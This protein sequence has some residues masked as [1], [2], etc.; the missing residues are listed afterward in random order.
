[1]KKAVLL[2]VVFILLFSFTSCVRVNRE[3]PQFMIEMISRARQII[4]AAFPQGEL[5]F[6]T[7]MGCFEEQDAQA[8]GAKTVDDIISWRF[9]FNYDDGQRKSAEISWLE[10]AWQAP[11]IVN[12]VWMED[13]I[14]PEPIF[15][16]FDLDEAIDILRMS[17]NWDTPD[18]IFSWVVFRKPLLPGI[19]EPYYIFT[20]GPGEFISV[21]AITGQILLNEE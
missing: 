8:R 3:E 10:G 6:F 5:S 20:V 19:T 9:I 13:S 14:I 11:K 7:A 12:D 2:V 1:M 18:D 17:G 15:V 4:Q 21:G 16:A